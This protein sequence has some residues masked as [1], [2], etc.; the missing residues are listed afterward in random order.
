MTLTREG[1]TPSLIDRIAGDT[2]VVELHGEIDVRAVL[3]VRA[4]LDGLTSGPGPD[5]TVDLG[6]VTFIDCSGLGLLCR[7]RNRTL[8]RGGRFRLVTDDDR[9]LRLLRLAGL[10]GVFEVLPGRASASARPEPETT[11]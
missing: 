8:L 7:A 4:R 3:S 2:T 9:I 6:A 10:G 1:A 5:V 11:P